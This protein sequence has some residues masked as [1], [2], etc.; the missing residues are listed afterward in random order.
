MPVEE[1]ELRLEKKG[2]QKLFSSIVLFPTY[3]V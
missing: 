3:I 1:L 2:V